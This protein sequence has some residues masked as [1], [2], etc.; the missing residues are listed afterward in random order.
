MAFSEASKINQKPKRQASSFLTPYKD[1]T[2]NAYF[3]VGP[4]SSK[5]F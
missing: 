5:S 4:S 1:K 2:S 3:N